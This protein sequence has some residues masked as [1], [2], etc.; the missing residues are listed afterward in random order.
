MQMEITTDNGERRSVPLRCRIDTTDEL[1][2]FQHGGIL[3][4]V[5]EQLAA[6]K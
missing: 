5:L 1:Q 6:D 4:Y 3:A 2:Y